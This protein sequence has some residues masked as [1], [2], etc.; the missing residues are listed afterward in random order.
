M[1]GLWRSADGIYEIQLGDPMRGYKWSIIVGLTEIV[2][3]ALAHESP[4]PTAGPLVESG[5]TPEDCAIIAAQAYAKLKPVTYWCEI[6]H[7]GF[8]KPKSKPSGHAMVFYKYHANGHVFAYD[9]RGAKELTT[10]AQDPEAIAVA[11]QAVL[12][13]KNVRVVMKFVTS[14]DSQERTPSQSS[15]GQPT[16]ESIPDHGLQPS[17]D[18]PEQTTTASKGQETINMIMSIIVVIAFKAL[19]GGG[20][21]WLI[22]RSKNRPEAGFWWGFAIGWIGWLIVALGKRGPARPPALPSFA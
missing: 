22:G 5:R 8:T 7:V 10:T 9:E 2:E 20:V 1:P 17:K 3:D 6:G 13:D 21:G 14:D 4:Q 16:P 19:F 18:T 12:A 15:V 11:L